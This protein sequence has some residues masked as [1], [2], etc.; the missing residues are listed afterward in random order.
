MSEKSYRYWVKQYAKRYW[1]LILILFLLSLVSIVFD[2]LGP[3]P[4]KFLADNVFGDQPAPGILRGLSKQELLVIAALGYIL[5]HGVSSI[6]G[7]LFALVNQR[8]VQRIDRAALKEVHEAATTIPYNDNSRVESGT[9]IYQISNQSLQLSEYLLTSIISISQ[10]V[11]MLA[12]IVA[13]LAFLNLRITLIVLCVIPVLAV[14]V[15]RFSQLLEEKAD[16]AQKAHAN[17][18]NF[19]TESLEKLRT[20]QAF[21]LSN[22]RLIKLDELL[23]FYNHRSRSRLIVNESFDIS[24]EFVILI[25]TAIAILL[26]GSSVFTGMMTFGAL[27]IFISYIGDVFDRVDSVVVTIGEM[28]GQAVIIQQAYNTV[29]T[30]RTKYVDVGTLRE[31]IQ[32]RIEC[33]DLYLT[34]GANKVLEHV[35]LVIE[36]GS[37]VALVGPSGSG[38]STFLDSLLRFTQPSQGSLEIDGHNINEYNKTFLRQNISLIDQEPQLFDL[39][40]QENIAIA[41]QER[42]YNL[43]DVMGS[44]YVGNSVEFIKKLSKGYDTV[45]S[46][47]VLSGGQK[48]RLAISRAYYKNAHIILMDEPTS[49]LDTRSSEIFV[50]NV[51]AYFKGRTVVIVT[52]DLDLLQRIPIVYVVQDHTILPISHY[53]GLEA[54]RQTVKLV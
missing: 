32:G 4:L 33:K 19:V 24:T 53:G 12:S 51:L 2:L 20:I 14:L 16:E 6:Y 10:S 21:A 22:K 23:R 48:Q 18:Y 28:K 44:A 17:I 38:K 54:Y 7:M 34:R 1:Y 42:P 45:V 13:V 27:L 26:S 52:H 11:I 30:A 43:P 29:Y 9:Y 35:N 25:G 41:D 50:N 8:C 3:Y 31:P 47:T 40:V 37:V 36:P 46:N 39:S 49:A 5:I 15:V